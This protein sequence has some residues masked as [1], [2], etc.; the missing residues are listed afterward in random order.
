M[1]AGLMKWLKGS[2][3]IRPLY[4]IVGEEIFFTRE[5]KNRLR[6]RIFPE[7]E[8]TDFNYDN[9]SVVAGSANILRAAVETLPVMVERRLV[10]CRF[11][12][13]FQEKDW[14]VL[15]PVIENP[16]PSTV[17][18]LFFNKGDKR[19]KHFKMLAKAGEE[20]SA[21]PLREW[22]TEPW[23]DFIAEKEGLKFSPPAKQLFQQLVG[24]DLLETGNEMQKLKSYI[25]DRSSVQESDIPAVISRSRVDNVFHFT[26]AVGRKDTVRSLDLLAR[27]LEN[28]QNIVGVL[29]LLARHIRILS[30]IKEGRRKGLGRHQLT[31]TAGVPPYFMNNY[32]SQAGMWTD[33]Q[34]TRA[35]KALYETEKM[36]KSSPLPAHI[37]LENFVLKVCD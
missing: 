29:I 13:N 6:E 10:L 36:L 28:N 7:K 8:M 34:V 12:Q 30:R 21:T 31:V 26:D 11:A 37:W 19:K 25:G 20:L 2:P 3:P 27:L 35:M 24:S 5:I 23:I 16:V 18:A 9:L 32:L 15:K 14:E 22:E 1:S 17:L 33:L 4:F